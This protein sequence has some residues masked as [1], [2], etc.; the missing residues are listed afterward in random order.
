VR[1]LLIDVLRQGA[2]SGADSGQALFAEAWGRADDEICAL[3]AP[4]V[5]RVVLEEAGLRDCEQTAGR[6]PHM[7]ATAVALA[8]RGAHEQGTDWRGAL[9]DSGATYLMRAAASGRE[10]APALCAVLLEAG[11]DANAADS[12]GD[13]ALHHAARAG[14][15]AVCN[16]LM[17]GGADVLRRNGRNRTPGGQLHLCEPVRDVLA[18]AEEVERTARVERRRTAWDP[19]LAAT[20][21]ASACVLR[22]V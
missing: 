6:W 19:K 14:A 18:A 20:Q 16:V 15:V 17:A 3:L 7:P 2:R 12:A 22:A 4:L 13:T 11:A 10:A 21:T 1:R 5:A 9:D 8:V